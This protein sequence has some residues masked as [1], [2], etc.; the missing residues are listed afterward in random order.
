[1]KSN[2]SFSNYNSHSHYVNFVLMLIYPFCKGPFFSPLRLKSHIV[3]VISSAVTEGIMSWEV[4]LH[5][6][7]NNGMRGQHGPAS[8]EEGGWCGV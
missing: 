8:A 5:V 3:F 6:F 2:F 1:M 4:Q 7:S